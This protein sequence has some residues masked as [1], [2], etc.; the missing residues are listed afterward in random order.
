M[1]KIFRKDGQKGFTLIEL[2]IVVA[3]I[4]ILAAIA[5]PQFIQY[6]TRGWRTVVAE[7]VGRAAAEV[8]AWQTTPGREGQVAPADNVAAGALGAQ[9]TNF[10]T[11]PGVSMVVA[12]GG[13]PITGT[14]ANLGGSYILNCDSSVVNT[15]V[16]N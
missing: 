10:R 8:I 5:I 9:Y 6:R 1:L 11:S 15:L 4:G 16:A 14:H 2:M 3:I 13:C 12:G 7:D